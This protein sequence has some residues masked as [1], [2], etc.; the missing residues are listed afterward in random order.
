MNKAGG[1]LRGGG[2][3]RRAGGG[4]CG[5]AAGRRD[6]RLACRNRRRGNR[7][8]LVVGRSPATLAS[9]GRES[10]KDFLNFAGDVHRLGWE[11]HA[12]GLEWPRSWPAAGAFP[13]GSRRRRSGLGRQTRCGGWRAWQRRGVFVCVDGLVCLD[14]RVG[15]G[16]ITASVVVKPLDW[17][18]RPCPV[19]L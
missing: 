5:G 2:T 6:S 17:D 1:R 13:F 12:K 11:S 9:A 7:Q 14:G 4:T 19:L 8:A 15:G 3:D 16:T 18:A 10:S